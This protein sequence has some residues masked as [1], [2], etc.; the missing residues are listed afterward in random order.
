NLWESVLDK[1]FFHT[2][3]QEFTS[4]RYPTTDNNRIWVQYVSNVSCCKTK[5]ETNFFNNR[6]RKFITRVSRLK[7][8][9]TCNRIAILSSS[10]CARITFVAVSQVACHTDNTCCVSNWI[11]AAFVSPSAFTTVI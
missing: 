4:C 1:I 10:F 3:T 6:I 5:V 2:D 9:F 11:Q 8:V 7:D